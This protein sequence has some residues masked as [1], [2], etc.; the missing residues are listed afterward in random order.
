ML[1]E[2]S[3]LGIAFFSV[4]NCHAYSIL[5]GIVPMCNLAYIPATILNLC[6]LVQ[7]ML[8][9]Q[10][11]HTNFFIKIMKTMQAKSHTYH[12]F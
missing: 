3:I 1:R 5:R 6:C 2:N 8:S 10:L 11:K 7:Q 9:V 12:P 4:F